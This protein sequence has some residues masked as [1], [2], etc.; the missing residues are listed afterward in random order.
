LHTFG[1]NERAQAAFRKVGFVER[2]RQT[3]QRGRVDVHMTLVR[4]AW[5]ERRGAPI[6]PDPGHASP[7]SANAG[8]ADAGG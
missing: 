2:Q 1:D 5:F 8:G 7:A 3:G 6:A 4:S